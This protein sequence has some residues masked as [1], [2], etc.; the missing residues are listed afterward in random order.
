MCAAEPANSIDA[1]QKI[2]HTGIEALRHWTN[3]LNHR[4]FNAMDLD[5]G[6]IMLAQA[7]GMIEMIATL[8]S[9]GRDD[10]EKPSD[11]TNISDS[12]VAAALDGISTLI[13][14]AR[15]GA[16]SFEY[17]RTQKKGGPA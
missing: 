1:N 4:P 11:I 9:A 8:Y 10:A 16:D 7:Q 13:S 3:S 15:V 14:L 2:A 12:S 6:E 5:D 17:R